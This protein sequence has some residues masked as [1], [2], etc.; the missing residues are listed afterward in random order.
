MDRCYCWLKVY[1]R[2]RLESRGFFTQFVQPFS[3][4]RTIVDQQ[5]C[6][7]WLIWFCVWCK[8]SYNFAHCVSKSYCWLKVYARMRLRSCQWVPGD[9]LAHFVAFVFSI[10]HDELINNGVKFCESTIFAMSH[11]VGSTLVSS[12]LNWIKRLVH[13]YVHIWHSV[14]RLSCW[15]KAYARMRLGL[16]Q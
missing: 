7:L 5:R 10:S 12:F 15:P 1:A 3:Q 4:L 6:Q 9:F 8:Y 14:N 11:D 16:C 2:M 13:L